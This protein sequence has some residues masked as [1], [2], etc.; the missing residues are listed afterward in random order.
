MKLLNI[1]ICVL[2]GVLL[3]GCEDTSPVDSEQYKKEIYLVG[4]YDNVWPLNVMYTGDTP[5]EIF[6]TVSSSGSLNLDKDVKVE[7]D[8]DEEIIHSYNELFFGILNLDK[9]YLPLNRE[10]YNIPDLNNVLMEHKLGI[11]KNVPIF[12]ETTGIEPDSLYVIPIQIKSV[13]EYSVNRS[14]EKMLIKLNMVNAFSNQYSMEGSRILTNG[15]PQIIQKVKNL[16]A[17][18]KQSVRLFYGTENENA[19]KIDTQAIVLTVGETNTTEGENIYPVTITAWNDQKLTVK[20][21]IGTYN[22]EEKTYDITY[23]IEIDGVKTTYEEEL[24]L[25]E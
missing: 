25:V 10:R 12:I 19:E 22:A 24:T 20:D 5:S 14:G 16:K 11:S 3:V 15:N 8:V 7:L 1:L 17:V 2:F 23:S 18:N 21:G 13:S 9:Y 4:A 6:I